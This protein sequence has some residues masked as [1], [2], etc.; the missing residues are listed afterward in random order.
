MINNQE[1]YDIFAS[2][3]QQ[4]CTIDVASLHVERKRFRWLIPDA[5]SLDKSW[6]FNESGHQGLDGEVRVDEFFKSASF[7]GFISASAR[8][9]HVNMAMC[10]LAVSRDKTEERERGRESG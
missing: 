7:L 6:F 9:M 5:L 4:I 2:S 1:D 10:H 8:K 3:K